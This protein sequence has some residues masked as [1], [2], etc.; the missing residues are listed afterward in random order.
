MSNSENNKEKD[1]VA[2]A[3]D[4]IVTPLE[5]V[6]NGLMEAADEERKSSEPYKKMFKA[7]SSLTGLFRQ[8]EHEGMTHALNAAD[9]YANKLKGE[10]TEREALEFML[11]VPYLAFKL[12]QHIQE[13]QGRTCCVDKTFFLLSEY[14]LQKAG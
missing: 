7:G 10:A 13:I 5:E 4:A 14:F 12:E 9:I 11:A 1:A 8:L 3:V 6:M 2:S